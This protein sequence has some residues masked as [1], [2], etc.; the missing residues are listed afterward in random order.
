MKLEQR[1]PQAVAARQIPLQMLQPATDCSRHFDIF[2]QTAW[3]ATSRGGPSIAS[4]TEPFFV[5][6][7]WRYC[8]VMNELRSPPTPVVFRAVTVSAVASE[9]TRPQ[10]DSSFS[11]VHCTRPS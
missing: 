2:P 8:G 7:R 11:P 5:P 10:L 4:M 1:L 3:R 6:N 9:T